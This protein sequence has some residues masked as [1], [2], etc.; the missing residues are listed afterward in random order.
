MK[1]FFSKRALSF[2]MAL[3]MISGTLPLGGIVSMASATTKEPSVSIEESKV[4]LESASQDIPKYDAPAT[5]AAAP[6]SITVGT[7][8]LE[9]G[10]Y[11][12]IST[13]SVTSTKP[14]G[15]YFYYR[16][17]TLTM[18][19]ASYWSRSGNDAVSADGDLTID[20]IG[21]N[22]IN[23]DQTYTQYGNGIDVTG[24]LTF[25]GSGT[26]TVNSISYS[27]I[28]TGGNVYF[29]QSGKVTAT[30]KFSSGVYCNGAVT[31]EGNLSATA[32]S[33]GIGLFSKNSININSGTV[34]V[35]A[36]APGTYPAIRS[37]AG[38]VIVNGGSLTVNSTYHG[39]VSKNAYSQRGGTVKITSTAGSG[40]VVE[41]TTSNAVIYAGTLSVTA[42]RYGVQAQKFYMYGGRG[43]IYSKNTAHDSTYCSVKVSYN[44]T[45]G[46]VTARHI[47]AT[48][49]TNPNGVGQVT[50]VPADL[51]SYDYVQ[52][53]SVIHVNG[54]AIT[55]G[56][57]LLSSN[58]SLSST[59]PSSG[60]YAYYENNT[61]TLYNYTGTN[62]T[63]YGIYHNYDLKIVLSGTNTLI[64]SSVSSSYDGIYVDGALYVTG[65][66]NLSI[67]GGAY[68]IYTEGDA[69]IN[70]T[71]VSCATSGIYAA[72]NMT[73]ADS[74]ISIG[75][76]N[77]IAQRTT[78]LQ[79]YGT[80]TISG[81]SGTV[82]VNCPNPNG[83][84]YSAGVKGKGVTISGGTVN[85]TT[86]GNGIESTADIS[87]SGGTIN[88]TSKQDAI[89]TSKTLNVTGGYVTATG[90]LDGLDVNTLNVTW[91]SVIATSTATIGETLYSAINLAYD[92]PDYFVI[93]SNLGVIGNT[94]TSATNAMPIEVEDLSENDYVHIGCFV[95]M[96]NVVLPSGY[97]LES[98]NS[99]NTV[100]FSKPTSG[101]Y[102]YYAN[103][104]LTL[105]NYEYSGSS[106][107]IR[108]A[109]SITIKTSAT[110]KVNHIISH[111]GDLTFAGSADL[112]IK[113]NLGA[114]AI[115][116]PGNVFFDSGNITV[117]SA[118]DG[119]I[120]DSFYQRGAL[121]W[122]TATYDGILFDSTLSVT[123]GVIT[124]KSTNTSS[125]GTYR[126][127]NTETD[128]AVIA[129]N[130]MNHMAGQTAE[131]GK[132]SVTNFTSLDFD[133]VILGEFVMMHGTFLYKGY[134]I[135]NGS[136]QIYQ[137]L[138]EGTTTGF[139]QLQDNGKLLLN[140]YKYSGTETGIISYADLTIVTRGDDNSIECT[141]TEEAISVE[142]NLIFD[143]KDTLT[144]KSAGNDAIYVYDGDLTIYG[145]ALYVTGADHGILL[146]GLY[147]GKLTIYGGFLSAIST[148]TESDSSYR[149]IKLSSTS[150]YSLEG[151][152]T[153]SASTE[154]TAASLE[155]MN[156]EKLPD[157]DC[158]VIGDYVV[159]GGKIVR[160]GYSANG[161]NVYKGNMGT[162]YAYYYA[163]T[164]TVDQLRVVFGNAVG[165]QAFEDLT[166]NVIG[167]S[168][169]TVTSGYDGL[170][171]AG[172]LT[173]K[174]PKEL[175]INSSATA[176]FVYGN[177]TLSG[178]KIIL[179]GSGSNETLRVKGLTVNSGILNVVSSSNTAILAEGGNVTVNGGEFLASGYLN[180]VSLTSGKLSVNGGYFEIKSRL[181][182]DSYSALKLAANSSLY[183]T[184]SSAMMQKA[185]T[186]TN[187]INLKDLVLEDLSDY[188]CIVIGQFIEV[189]GKTLRSGQSINAEGTVI[190]G[191]GGIG[192]AYYVADANGEKLTLNGISLTA[193]SIQG[194]NS[195]TLI[196]KTSNSIRCEGVALTVN[197]DL[198]IEGGGTLTVLSDQHALY[199]IGNVT[200]TEVT[201]SLTGKST[202]ALEMIPGKRLTVTDSEVTIA[203]ETGKSATLNVN[204]VELDQNLGILA[205]PNA[206]GTE[207]RM[208]T[209]EELPAYKYVKIKNVNYITIGDVRL[210][211][212]YSMSST[213]TIVKGN[214]GSGYAYF[215]NGVLTLNGFSTSGTVKADLALTL[216]IFG[217]NTLS[218]G[219]EIGD[220]L[221]VTGTGSLSVTG[222]SNSSITIGGDFLLQ[223]GDLT[224]ENSNSASLKLKNNGKKI[225]INGG[226]LT[227]V[228][229]V[230]CIGC[231]LILND[232]SVSITESSGTA[233]EMGESTGKLAVYGGTL[234]VRG[235]IYGIAVGTASF[236]G[237]VSVIIGAERYALYCFN[238]TAE[239]DMVIWGTDALNGSYPQQVDDPLG[240][241]HVK[242]EYDNYIEIGGVRLESGHSIDRNGNVIVGNGGSGYAYYLN[243][244]LTLNG[245][246][247]SNLETRGIY[248]H[249]PLT[250]QLTNDNSISVISDDH[251]IYVDGYLIVCGTGSLTVST[252]EAEQASKDAVVVTTGFHMQSG[253]LRIESA[254]VGLSSKNNFG[255]QFVIDGGK[256]TIHSKNI[257]IATPACEVIIN[258]GTVEINTSSHNGIHIGDTEG[259]VTVNGGTLNVSSTVGYGIM[260]AC[261][262]NG[263]NIVIQTANQLHGAFS[264]SVTLGKGMVGLGSTNADG[265]DLEPMDS[266]WYLYKYVIITE[267]TDVN[268]NCIGDI[269][270]TV[271]GNAVTV[272]HETTCQV[273]YFDGSAY[274]YITPVKNSDGSYT[275]TAPVG[276]TEVTLM[277][278]G[279]F[280]LD[281]KI[282]ISDVTKLLDV[283]AGIE[284]LQTMIDADLNADG[285]ISISDIT[286][287]LDALAGIGNL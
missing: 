59:K 65:S 157:Y 235:N 264:S 22:F 284:T 194:F 222:T 106:V 177:M 39:I 117:E 91:G 19:G 70:S 67:S 209:V 111:K 153:E 155:K 69:V 258:G 181:K 272:D 37:S 30:S 188:G 245:F 62:T 287:L 38:G 54:Y 144:L 236:Y 212:G 8:T 266:Y 9:S 175:K 152:L 18:N 20:L 161:S 226:S 242:I 5:Q 279:D 95:L 208:V 248:A 51:G 233:L 81:N 121:A 274:V 35:S 249:E 122:V 47:K 250:L 76:L 165:I 151:M 207:L 149:A 260:G 234:T 66:G 154:A 163:G 50:V 156:K 283:L 221:T 247:V 28:T 107:A 255:N 85:L 90:A 205:G 218:G 127:I 211:S 198:T 32:T 169:I 172:N 178:S 4:E 246:N 259:F 10:K 243:G 79:A 275:F 88:V 102:A 232:G 216:Q 159:I 57:Y 89:Y 168:F 277:V 280:T 48:A 113:T 41:N 130:G 120:C 171:V 137:Q 261:F 87:I 84:Y 13:S 101:K 139:A 11:F 132:L 271:S 176:L 267:Q 71:T 116:T 83:S 80:V 45:S 104:V 2:L 21:S 223:S 158:V 44:T 238:V 180:G 73:L 82:T 256:L 136:N 78:A 77:T 52:F 27:S 123:G 24:N 60:G 125:D 86:A 108:S 173:L 203:T 189:G 14:E 237:G 92:T 239:D 100:S 202:V 204:V 115:N 278:K 103:G 16:N 190:D 53:Y 182:N 210:D 131:P 7:T 263:G 6:P 253:D 228:G 23:I 68:A 94:S 269:D 199:C 214:G 231:D 146:H 17:G 142:G 25:I 128:S 58:K 192:Y 33:N 196:L 75:Q 179:N 72:G 63:D 64:T 93:A 174:G 224:I 98:G 265:T 193:G 46:F 195:L 134:Y 241:N 26:L 15:G 276:V 109:N 191:N 257:G 138:P 184:A 167:D 143:G 166:I 49:A 285:N 40:I 124:V 36:D 126:A 197:G 273:C 129:L 164:L 215:E 12:S 240:Y 262:F 140:G 185:S 268:V 244:T 206:D 251:A 217:A 200:I 118:N 270:Y 201:V 286:K 281:G 135:K 183:Y 145:G 252:T 110:S 230:E 1:K 96:H 42:D 61:L 31:I 133:F 170:Y 29:Y 3:V 213:G 112:T 141:G 150:D 119:I 34:S 254:N 55:D 97:Y 282:T 99:A 147:S 160:S 229:W 56:Q 74:K 187:T 186:E 43:Y 162:G 219:M 148:N 225:V 105:Q 114:A 227:V 220:S